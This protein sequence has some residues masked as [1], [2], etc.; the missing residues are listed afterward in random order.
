[1]GLTAV[2]FA[3]GC[4]ET[5]GFGWSSV[6]TNNSGSDV[7]VRYRA[8]PGLYDDDGPLYVFEVPAGVEGIGLAQSGWHGTLEVLDLK[9]NVLGTISLSGVASPRTTIEQGGRPQPASNDESRRSVS[10]EL[11]PKGERCGSPPS[12]NP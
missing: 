10:L 7:L 3:A 5:P 6:V 2:V 1:M 11:T 12:A 8:D 9:C 4:F